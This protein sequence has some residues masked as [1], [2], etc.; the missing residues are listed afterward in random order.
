MGGSI[1]PRTIVTA[2]GECKL[3]CAVTGIC[4]LPRMLPRSNFPES[5]V[6]TA[7]TVIR[8]YPATVPCERVPCLRRVIIALFFVLLV[9]PATASN[10]L[11][12]VDIPLQTMHVRVDGMTKY[13]WDVSTGR[14]GYTTP[15]GRYRPIRMLKKWYS[16]KYDNAPMPYAIF[17]MAVTP[18][19]ARAISGTLVVSP[20][21]AA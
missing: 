10:I 15:S 19:T 14:A 8:Q 17:F 11:V 18:F 9:G 16:K 12:V 4:R 13:R 20:R 6:N 1:W 21:T 7:E 2:P 3:I 5:L